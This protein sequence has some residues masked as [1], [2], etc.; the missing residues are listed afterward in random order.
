MAIFF[1]KEQRSSSLLLINSLNKKFSRHG[2]T[3]F[4]GQFSEGILK[5]RKIRDKIS[6]ITTK[7]PKR[8]KLLF[9]ARLWESQNGCD[10]LWGEC[11]PLS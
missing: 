9:R 4:V 3:R 1:A 2:Y 11:A 6:S 7:A 10:M 5:N 8:Y